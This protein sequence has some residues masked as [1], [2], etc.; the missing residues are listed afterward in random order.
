MTTKM[1]KVILSSTF[2]LVNIG[3]VWHLW[4]DQKMFLVIFY[5]SLKKFENGSLKFKNLSKTHKFYVD[6]GQKR[7][8]C[9]RDP[10]IGSMGY[11]GGGYKLKVPGTDSYPVN[12]CI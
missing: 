2:C 3:T 7:Y 5:P 8:L 6:L 4:K 1:L 11:G 10:I 9:P 12:E